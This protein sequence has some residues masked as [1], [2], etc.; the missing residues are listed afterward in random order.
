MKKKK[1]FV[2]YIIFAICG[3]FLVGFLILFIYVMSQEGKVPNNSGTEAVQTPEDETAMQEVIEMTGSGELVEQKIQITDVNAIV[4]Y[5][6]DGNKKP[7][8]ILQHGLTGNKESF[9]EF[10]R[11]LAKVGYLVVLPDAYAH[12]DNK[13]DELPV[14]EEAVE[15]AANFETIVEYYQDSSYVDLERLGLIGFSL[16]GLASYYYT[17]NAA[18]VPKV[19]GTFCAT[20]D[21]ETMVGT[22]AS[23]TTYSNKNTLHKSK[24]VSDTAKQQEIDTFI[25][26][27]SPYE[28]LL[29]N[30][31]THYCILGGAADTVVP[32][33]GENRFYDAHK[34]AA[35]MT[36]Q[37]YENQGHEATEENMWTMLHYFE[38]HL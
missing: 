13:D 31:T 10:G 23:Y 2:W 17:A 21:W 4:C 9:L 37:L 6:D 30:D 19:V 15:T 28:K 20:P 32:T 14:L 3:L 36:L 34:D 8:V 26:E 25:R 33:E 35:D 5:V 11:Q 29:E 24:Y 27:H 1:D 38:N 16:G 7:F 18:V 12:G 22:E